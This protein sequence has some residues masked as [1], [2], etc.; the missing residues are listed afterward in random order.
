MKL[1][2]QIV[3]QVEE[4]HARLGTSREVAR[5]FQLPEE[6]VRRVLDG[7]G[8]RAKNYQEFVRAFGAAGPPPEV[9]R[10]AAADTAMHL[11]RL[12]EIR[13][14][15][16]FV[17]D[18]LVTLSQQQGEVVRALDPWCDLEDTTADAQLRSVAEATLRA[19]S[20]RANPAASETPARRRRQAPG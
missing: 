1:P 11:K 8:L 10:Q 16:K 9:L 13:G 7:K 6:A 20:P 18:Q 5:E 3:R 14:Y 2:A 15:A 17:Y 19:A 4:A 12:Q